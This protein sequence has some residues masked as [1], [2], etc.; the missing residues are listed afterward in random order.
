MVKS[1]DSALALGELHAS[2]SSAH[3]SASAS[4]P[5]AGSIMD[6]KAQGLRSGKVLGIGEL[7]AIT[8]SASAP[9]DRS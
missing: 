8:C 9:L 1:C 3:A 5:R 7:L 6:V 2:M 4:T